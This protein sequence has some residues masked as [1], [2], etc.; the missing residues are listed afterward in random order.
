MFESSTLVAELTGTQLLQLA[1]QRLQAETACELDPTAALERLR[2]LMD[3]RERLQAVAL[4]AIR[5]GDVR[6]LFALDG[7]G[8]I[9]GWLRAQ[10]C[11][12]DGQ[13]MLARRLTERP[14]VTG[15][16][17]AGHIGVR[18]A[19]QLCTALDKVPAHIDDDIVTAVI[20]DG[21]GQLLKAAHG[22]SPDDALTDQGR[23]QR[24]AD[25][26]L[27]ADAAGRIELA[28]A[29]R[30]EPGLVLLARRL[31][32]NLLGTALRQLVQAI[33]P[34]GTDAPAADPYFL[35]L[36]PLLDGDWD[37]LGLLDPATGQALAD[38]LARHQVNNDQHDA[39]RQA[40]HLRLVSVTNTTGSA[41]QGEA[42]PADAADSEPETAREQ[43][44]AERARELALFDQA[45]ADSFA[46]PGRPGTPVPVGRW[47]HDAFAALLQLA[48]RAD[49]EAST[50]APAELTI[51]CQLSTLLGK[52]GSLPGLL[53]RPGSPPVPLPTATLQRL[54]CHSILSAVL[55]DAAGHPIGAA[56]THRHANRRERRA[57]RAQWGAT[58]AVKGCA[59]TRTVPH[60][61]HP[62]WTSRQTILKDLAPLCQHCHHDLH[63]GRRTLLLRN[64]RYIN[65]HGWATQR[66]TQ[67]A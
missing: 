39:D 35:Q 61:V 58:C 32:P 9:R 31:T 37:L 27:L 34:D 8:S 43:V 15:A 26:A 10:P 23:A 60:H 28:P 45:I 1:V 22:A 7:A 50:P 24:Q 62:W 41:S 14:Q 25:L 49:P 36:R 59:N 57:M 16:L 51:T 6:E 52:A 29:P 55:T 12:D 3:S 30:C 42:G 48:S 66:A 63:E 56:S 19:A 11:G 67:S 17:A 64:G 65:E 33:Q 4:E 2:V 47:R 18:A 44:E 40:V 38:Q 5:D 21:I 46:R 53:H 54:G 13:L 20:I